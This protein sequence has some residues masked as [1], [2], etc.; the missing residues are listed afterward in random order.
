MKKRI[1][2]MFLAVNMI[3]AAAS[4]VNAAEGEKD[5]LGAFDETVKITTVTRGHSTAVYPEGDDA[6]NNV[7]TRA[8]KEQLNID[9]EFLWESSDEYDT[10]LNL[11]IASGQ[12]PDVFECNAD[13]LQKLMD[14][15]ML[16][17]LSE[18][19]EEYASD[20]L[21]KYQSDYADV[22]AT[23]MDG[24]ALY[25]IPE[26]DFMYVNQPQCIWIRDDWKEELGLADPETMEDFE[27][28]CLAFMENGKSEYGL[29]VAK[30][31][32]ELIQL[33]PGWQYCI[34]RCTGRNEKCIDC[35]G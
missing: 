18:V 2:S 13:Q 5:P 8:W 21:K 23:A 29:S 6:T 30:S 27:N 32:H 17:D 25:G 3:V 28:I 14:A 16:M 9:V 31:L 35:M 20:R 1:I 19:Y 15:G 10:K 24:E 12:I 4:Y 26:M 34:W 7:Y 22:Y 33:A 11:A